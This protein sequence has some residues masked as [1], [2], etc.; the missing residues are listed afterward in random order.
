MPCTYYEDL[1]EG[2]LK[3]SGKALRST[4]QQ[5]QTHPEFRVAGSAGFRASFLCFVSGIVA[6]VVLAKAKRLPVALVAYFV[7]RAS[8]KRDRGIWSH[9]FF[10]DQTSVKLPVYSSF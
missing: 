3:F 9:L 1:E 4:N 7:R 8:R 6:F 10:G 2:Q 5:H